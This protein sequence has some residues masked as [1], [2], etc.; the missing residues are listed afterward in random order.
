MGLY[1]LRSDSVLIVIEFIFQIAASQ[2][3][4]LRKVLVSLGVLLSVGSE[5]LLVNQ[6]FRLQIKK[7]AINVIFL[8]GL[9][10]RA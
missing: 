9:I 5:V 4:I 7:V 2:T 3:P 6:I 8:I 1:F 10:F